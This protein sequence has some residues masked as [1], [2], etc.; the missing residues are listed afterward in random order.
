MQSTRAT[1][2]L[3]VFFTGILLVM[4]D[5][6]AASRQVAEAARSGYGKLVFRSEIPRSARVEAATAAGVTLLDYAPGCAAAEAYKAL[7]SEVIRRVES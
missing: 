5:R 3:T 7:C 2:H 4:T 6:T 1:I